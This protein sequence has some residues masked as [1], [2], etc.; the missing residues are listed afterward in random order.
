MDSS[1]KRSCVTQ[2]LS[3]IEIGLLLWTEEILWILYISTSVKHLTQPQTKYFCSN[4]GFK[5]Q[6]SS[7]FLIGRKQKVVIG[8]DI[9]SW[10]DVKSGVFQGSVLGPVLFAIYVNNLPQVVESLI[11]LFTDDTK[12]YCS[13][14]S[15]LDSIQLQKD[16]DNFLECSQLWL[17]N[18]SNNKWKGMRIAISDRSPLI[19]MLDGGQLNVVSHQKNLGIMVD[20]QFKFHQHTASVASK[21]NRVLGIISKS[22]ECLDVD[23][24][25]RLYKALVRPIIECANSIWSP[26]YIGDQKKF[27]NVL[28]D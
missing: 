28:P 4:L 27:K 10:C 25:P 5:V 16:I 7:G 14:T 21:A 11:A 17:L 6:W 15:D 18:T 26:F 22:F 13:I 20:H 23:S 8:N 3:A 19:Y 1:F 12:L 2:L 9:S 24:L